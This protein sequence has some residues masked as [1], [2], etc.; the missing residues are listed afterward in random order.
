MSGRTIGRHLTVV[1]PGPLALIEDLGRPGLAR[2]GVTGSGAADREA[3]R[4]ANRLV[5]NP[6]GAA[7]L[8]L[9]LGEAGLMASNPLVVAVT[10]PPVELVV[11]R[12]DGSS[13]TV[14]SHR[15][16]ALATGDRLRI[17]RPVRGLRCVLAVRG[18]IAVE[19]VLGSRSGDP[20]TGIGPAPLVAGAVLG[21]GDEPETPVPGLGLELAVAFAGGLVPGQRTRVRARRGPR[22]DWFTERAL[23]LLES[24]W[25]RVGAASD[26][27][28]VRLEGPVLERCPQRS[29]ELP[30]EPVVRGAIQVSASG[31]PVVFGADHPTT[32]GYPV[33]AVVLDADLDLFGQLVPGERLGIDLVG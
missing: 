21:V 16:L 29:G 27:V 23:G 17:G 8:E 30:S 33:I 1:E 13:R 9:L 11:E 10:G 19:P 2:F 4:L 15:P 18:G 32:G 28:G 26:R 24:T 20:T 7:G 22:D 31:Q 25:W 6:E 5:G 14:A 3:L 12:A